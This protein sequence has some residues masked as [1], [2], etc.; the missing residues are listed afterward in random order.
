MQYKVIF[1]R[2]WK[3]SLLLSSWY[4]KVKTPSLT[5]YLSIARFTSFSKV[6]TLFQMQT[7]LSWIWNWFAAYYFYYANPNTTKASKF[8]ERIYI[9]IYIYIYIKIGWS[10]K[11]FVFFRIVL[12]ILFLHTC[13][14]PLCCF[15]HSTYMAQGLVNGVLNETWTYSLY[16]WVCLL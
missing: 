16:L 2:V 12:F 14:L 8:C 15:R 13:I 7:V 6:L 3:I 10:T 1:S 11:T 9:Y 4:G 5:Y